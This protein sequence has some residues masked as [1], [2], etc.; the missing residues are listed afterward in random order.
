MIYILNGSLEGFK[1]IK[2]C[3]AWRLAPFFHSF[4]RISISG[5]LKEGS[6]A[7][8]Q[9]LRHFRMSFRSFQN[10]IENFDIFSKFFST[11]LEHQF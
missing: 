4:L 11:K 7:R 2:N 1:F 3:F 5:I 10:L 9:S 8:L 6:H